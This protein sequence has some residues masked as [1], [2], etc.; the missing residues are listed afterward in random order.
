MVVTSERPLGR[1]PGKGKHHVEEAP[2]HQHPGVAG[3][4]SLGVIGMTGA[5]SAADDT[6]AYAKR[7]DQSTELVAV[8]D[9]DDDDDDT[10]TG[11][12]TGTNSGT[13]TGAGNGT[14]G[15]NTQQAGQTGTNTATKTGSDDSTSDLTNSTVHR[16]SQD[17][18]IS[19]GDKTK[20]RT[21]DGGDSTRDL[22]PNLTERQV[23][24]RHA[25]P[26]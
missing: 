24:Q 17:R 6:D 3:A 9:D 13:G 19:Q 22:T 18:D 23:A 25:E 2:A 26:S 5:A 11:A 8:A 14:S 7:E 1:R 10:D 12:D 4:L 16:A 20:D 15:T 21:M